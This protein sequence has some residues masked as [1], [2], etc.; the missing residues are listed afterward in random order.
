[1]RCRQDPISTARRR[2]SAWHIAIRAPELADK[3]DSVSRLHNRRSDVRR[4][5]AIYLG[6]T[7][8]YTSVQPTR[9][10]KGASRPLLRNEDL[11]LLGLAPGGVCPA[12]TVTSPA[13]G[14]LHHRFTLTTRRAGPAQLDAWRYAFCC[15]LPSGHPAWPLASTVLYGVR[16]FLR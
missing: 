10:S 12:E 6:C 11:P 15:T 1:M 4:A 2:S 5:A 13:G 7:L 9:G 14:L 3:P 16:T 8:P